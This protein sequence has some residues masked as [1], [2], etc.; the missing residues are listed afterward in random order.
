MELPTPRFNH[1]DHLIA[2][3]VRGWLESPAPDE[4]AGDCV[5]I[6]GWMFSTTSGVADIWVDIRGERRPLRTRLLRTDVA[7]A[8]PNEPSALESG[9]SAYLEFDGGPA[10][11]P[12]L[13]AIHAA[14]EDGRTIRLFNRRLR[15]PGTPPSPI[16][17]AWREAMSRPRSLISLR[18]WRAGWRLL[19]RPIGASMVQQPA[20][21]TGRFD[22]LSHAVLA[23]FMASGARL[24]LASSDPPRVSVIVPVWNRA[25]LT[26]A[27]LRALAAQAGVPFET[28][29]VDNGSADETAALLANVDGV[30]VLRNGT[31]R[32]F[33][34]AA[35]VGAANARG[36]FL[37]FLNNDAELLPG[38]LANLVASARAIPNVGAVGGKLVLPDGRLQEAGSIV[39]ADGSCEAYGRGG[40]PL[41]PE[42][43]FERPVDF[44]SGAL[45]L[46]PRAVFAELSGFD[47]GYAPAYY[48]DADYCVRLWMRG[49]PVVYQPAAI[50]VH[51]E[52]G[53]SVSP[54]AGI[55]LQRQRRGR[56]AA[57]HHEWLSHQRP[58]DGD[59]LAARTHPHGAPSLI[60][61]DDA[62]PDPRLGAGFPR[63]A[64][65]VAAFRELGYLV[66]VYATAAGA[67]RPAD[68]LPGVEVVPGGA[69]GL[70]PF[71]AARRGADL[72]V[73]S[74][75]HN[76]QYVKAAAGADLA[77]LGAPCIYDAEAIFAARDFG[78]RALAG[79]PPADAERRAAVEAELGLARGCSAVLVVSAEEQNLFAAAT[80]SPIFIVDHAVD[81]AAT[82]AT[83]EERRTLLFVGA[84]GPQSPNDDAVEFFVRGVL[85][86]LRVCGC[87][88]PFV[89]AGANAPNRLAARSA[90]GGIEVHADVDDLTPLYR[91]ARVF[92]APTRFGAGIPL[93]VIEAAARGVPVVAS[94]LVARQL[95]WEPDVELLA[96][97]SAEDFAAAIATLCRDRGLWM[98]VRDAALA[99]VQR[100]H[101]LARFRSTI[102]EAIHTARTQPK[103]GRPM[104][105]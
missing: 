4:A 77:G 26:F 103:T 81:T 32:G 82:P 84:F 68:V 19:L 70:R 34:I 42:Y 41:A 80:A 59:V 38:A 23:N 7:A 67:A 86:R 78:R 75:P 85:P 9:F 25:D 14:L 50:A 94:T 6:A 104:T 30:R 95:G 58:R 76:M 36:E 64:A 51:R 92:V 28:I 52:F 33:T 54:A 55:E 8:Y 47:E 48:E 96:G 44:C 69:S 49:H 98:R 46:T 3:D 10:S 90:Q 100:D 31:N 27:C 20:D 87:S 16:A 83:A 1:D 101:N 13:L 63:A 60:F 2:P 93:K 11:R 79:A 5:F 91:E 18:A 97:D 45:L 15:A 74:R 72:I 56:F 24:T 73:V 21:A 35:N 88:A 43:A 12:R 39:W 102:E 61:V 62:A 57:S 71:L 89:I 17:S 53:S 66:T 40:D 105:R 99:R 22:R 65:M 29:V 37:L